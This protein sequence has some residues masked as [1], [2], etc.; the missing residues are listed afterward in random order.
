M[1]KPES[2]TDRRTWDGPESVP[3]RKA[4]LGPDWE[5][6]ESV[7]V[8]P[9]AIA[10]ARERGPGPAPAPPAAARPAPTS[11]SAPRRL[12]SDPLGAAQPGGE[13]ARQT[14]R[15][16]VLVVAAIAIVSLVLALVL[17]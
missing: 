11:S 17:R 2:D 1:G 7:P 8:K 4:D 16:I 15:T 13:L 14:T 10:A 12:Q 9:E 3:V 5:G 6:P